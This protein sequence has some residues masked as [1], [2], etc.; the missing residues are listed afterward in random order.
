M[1]MTRTLTIAVVGGPMYDRLYAQQLPRFTAETGIDVHIG[2]HLIHAD[3]NAH[4]ASALAEGVPQ[5]DLISSHTKY[6]PSQAR[7]LLPL[8]PLLPPGYLDD[9]APGIVEQ[10]RVDGQLLGIP[11]NI[12]TR[13]IHYRTDLFQ[14]PEERRAFQERFGYELRPPATWDEL[15]DIARHFTRPPDLFGFAF[16]GM[17][18][19]L[20]GTFYELTK[21]YGGDFFG[22]NLRAAFHSPAGMQALTLLRDLYLTWRVTPPDLPTWQ[23]DAISSAFDAGRVAMIADWPATYASHVN[24]LGDRLGVARYPQGPAGRFVYSGGFTWAIPRGTVDRE[25]ALMLLMF[26]ASPQSQEVEARQGTYVPRRSVQRKIAGAIQPGTHERYRLE[27]LD[28]TVEQY[29]LIPPRLAQ[30]PAIEDAVW[31]LLQAG[32]IGEL[33]VSEAL[34]S[35]ERAMNAIL[36][37]AKQGNAPW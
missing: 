25:A 29:L 7:W 9:F 34:A 2:A 19:G 8:D 37:E 10:A 36:D 30:Y 22:P 5:Y 21:M 24:A 12:D 4:L 11:R 15:L 18:S 33:P 14:D 3:L 35:A 31:P 1:P 32:V 28:E 23:F 20:W 6:A 26:L 13:L 16:P 27:L 17:S